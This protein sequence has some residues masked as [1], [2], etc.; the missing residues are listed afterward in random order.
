MSQP[1]RQ[2]FGPL[3]AEIYHADFPD[4]YHGVTVEAALNSLEQ[5]F[6]TQVA[7]DRVAAILV[8]PVQGDGGFRQAP[9]AFLQAVREMATRHGIVLI[10]DEIQ[11]GFGRTGDLFGF[12]RSGIRPD[13][14]TIAKSVAGGLP[15]SGVVGRA[16]IMDGPLPGGLGG[17]YGGNAVACAAAMAVLD[18]FE[19]DNLL[20][21]GRA[22]GARLRAG[23]EALQQRHPAIGEV[24][25]RGPML[26]ME[27]VTDRESRRPDAATAQAIIDAARAEGLLV[28]KCGVHR[29]VI[30]LLAP[31]VTSGRQADEALGML[32][33]ALSATTKSSTC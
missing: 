28:I 12:E 18:V 2:N 13:L 15:L 16:E 4:A 6:A 19:E 29:N 27:I 3:P 32:S 25:G 23:L 1:Y 22:L 10:V 24:R 26:A 7:P 14:V 11:T 5:L 33:R 17:T 8:E 20:E 31:L 9:D 30:R 21:R